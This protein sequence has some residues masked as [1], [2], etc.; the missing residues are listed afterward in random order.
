MFLGR[1]LAGKEEGAEGF[2]GCGLLQLSQGKAGPWETPSLVTAD[3]LPSVQCPPTCRACAQQRESLKP[4]CYWDNIPVPV[5]LFLR[6]KTMGNNFLL[7][8]VLVLLMGSLIFHSS[9]AN[10]V[11]FL[12]ILQIRKLRSRVGRCKPGGL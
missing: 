12:F 5:T 3:F 2:V 7:S 8:P 9:P 1:S 10:R 11:T 6:K 4:C